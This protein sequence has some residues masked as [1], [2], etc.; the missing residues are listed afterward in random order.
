MN[1]RRVNPP[2]EWAAVINWVNELRSQ[3]GKLVFVVWEGHGWFLVLLSDGSR[4]VIP[5][6]LVE[7]SS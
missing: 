6:F 5:E 1:E 2:V 3:C 7:V 4:I